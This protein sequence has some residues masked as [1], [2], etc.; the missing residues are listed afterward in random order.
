MNPMFCN[1]EFLSEGARLRGRRYAHHDSPK[2]L[3]IVIMA[4]RF[5]ATIQG[6]VADWYAEALH[7]AGL[8]ILLCDHR[9]FGLS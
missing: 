8:A 7:D 5:S 9:N 3:P 6:M 2:P 4:H 1:V